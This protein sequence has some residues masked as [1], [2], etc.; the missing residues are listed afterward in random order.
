[1]IAGSR[2]RGEVLTFFQ[3]RKHAILIILMC[4]TILSSISTR[5]WLKI[6]G[7]INTK[8]AV[9]ENEKEE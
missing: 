6:N 8:I 1:M 2:E 4:T 3:Y 5:V 7:L 9:E